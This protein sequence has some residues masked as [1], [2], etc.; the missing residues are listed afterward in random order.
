MTSG[1]QCG[2]CD[3]PRIFMNHTVTTKRVAP[4]CNAL[5]PQRAQIILPDALTRSVYESKTFG[6][7][8]ESYLPRGKPF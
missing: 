6:L 7:F 1:L 2:G 8:W 4:A 5:I 3:R